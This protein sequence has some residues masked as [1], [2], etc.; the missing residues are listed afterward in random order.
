MPP[1]TSY[2]ACPWVPRAGSPGVETDEY[3]IE[4]EHLSRFFTYFSH[5]RRPVSRYFPWIRFHCRHFFSFS[6]FL[7]FHWRRVRAWRS[8]GAPLVLIIASF[9]ARLGHPGW[10]LY[11]YIRRL[12]GDGTGVHRTCALA[13]SKTVSPSCR[14]LRAVNMN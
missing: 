5:W 1:V 10:L 6:F 8:W 7:S 2:M 11:K 14:L 9:L 4:L 13:R 12:K 3:W